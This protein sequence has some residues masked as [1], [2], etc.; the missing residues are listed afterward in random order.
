ML[1]LCSERTHF[2]I[3]D[4][5]GMKQI[6]TDSS[7]TSLQ[8]MQ[9]VAEK[10]AERINKHFTEESKIVILVGKG[11]NGG[12]GYALA[13]LLHSHIIIIPV[14][15]KPSSKEAIHM[16]NKVNQKYIHSYKDS[17]IQE[18]DLIVD[19]VYGFSFH[20][21]LKNEIKKI[22]R[23]INT[24]KKEVWSIDINSG[25]EADTGNYDID[26]LHATI[27]FAIECYKPFHMLR[28]EHQLFEKTELLHLNLQHNIISK[29]HTM[30][31]DIFF[32]HFP[33]KSETA[34]K[35][36]YGKTLLVGGGYGTAG[37]LSLNIIGAKTV[38]ASYINVAC[39]DEI[40]NI[41]ASHHIT[42]V[43]HPFGHETWNE[44][45]TPLIHEAKAIAYGSGAA[46]LSRKVECLDKIL[47]ESTKPVV[48]DAEALRL[49][50]HNTWI[51]RF[52][53]CPVIITPHL[54][55]F[56]AI[57]NQPNEVIRDHKIEFAKSFATKNKVYVIL[58]G[59]NTI[60]ASP[61]GEMYINQSGNQSLAQAGSG[62]LL[63]GILAG[64]LTLTTDIF[65]AICMA[66]WLHGYL[67]DYGLKKYAMQSFPLEKYPELMNE[68]FMKH[69]F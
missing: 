67:A 58:K 16:K 61:N 25:A 40:Y 32:S 2:M 41:V 7:Y 68:L 28:K 29:W 6:E 39:P 45:L 56:A 27:T 52:V 30:N 11:N 1:E 19:A 43:F 21:E 34:Y 26:A 20:G 53:K 55:E 59:P 49:L 17:Y 62:D 38:G 31:E 47:Q 13:P 22:F 46:K 15:G 24:L 36:T 12:D 48:L 3:I 9:K 42:P 63:T 37:A 23:S 66:V 8:L 60:V 18:A 57:C 69:R 33:K 14:D 10:I 51:L 54:G 5:N 44:T 35:G 4:T 65:T 50:V 64:I